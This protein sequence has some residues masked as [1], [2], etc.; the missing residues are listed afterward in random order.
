MSQIWHGHVIKSLKFHI[1]FIFKKFNIFVK[2]VYLSHFL[3]IG[4]L[5]HELKNMNLE[6]WASITKLQN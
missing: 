4:F 5:I 1:D 6:I 3:K 2:I